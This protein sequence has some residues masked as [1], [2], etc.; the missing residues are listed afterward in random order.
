MQEN[1]FFIIVPTYNRP[2]LVLRAINSIINQ[3]YSNY[4]VFIYNDG[5]NQSYKNL[6]DLIKDKKEINY[7]KLEKNIGIN[8]IRNIF[9]SELTKRKL[10][11]NTFIFTLSDDDYLIRDAL[12]IINNEINLHK[13]N[14][15]CFNVEKASLDSY[16][17]EKYVK[18]MNITYKH[19]I[20]EY[21]GDKHFIFRL[22]SVKDILY[23]RYFKNGY[24][25]IFY[26][27]VARKNNILV[28]PKLVKIIEYREDGLTLSNLYNN[29]N[30]Y[31]MIKIR[32]KYLIEDPYNIN[33]FLLM[34]KS[35]I[36]FHT[37]FKRKH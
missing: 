13:G 33:Y 25:E 12:K 19:F 26:N 11:P 31:E 37:F 23:P 32:A 6:E 34:L 29:K 21:K 10:Y 24:E 35:F 36:R 9:L 22:N 15:Y 28:I 5:S 7:T 17:N 4:E 2:Q 20:K 1:C 30:Y 16:H 14:W 3:G 8:K 18:Y 27:K